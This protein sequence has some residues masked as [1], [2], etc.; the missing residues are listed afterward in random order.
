MQC[1]L[2]S[3]VSQLYSSM[4]DA[5]AQTKDRAEILANMQIM[6]YLL[7][8]RLGISFQ[9]LD[10]KIISKLKLGVLEDG[11]EEWKSSLLALLRHMDKG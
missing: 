11:G 4:R 3:L 2:L 1:E 6:V 10:Q 8:E 9:V 5:N 7:A